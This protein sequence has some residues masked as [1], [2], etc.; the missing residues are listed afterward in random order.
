MTIYKLLM[1]RNQEMNTFCEANKFHYEAFDFTIKES[2]SDVFKYAQNDLSTVYSCNK[3]RSL[4]VGDL[5]LDVESDQLFL[6]RGT[7]YQ[8]IPHDFLIVEEEGS[9]I[10]ILKNVK[11]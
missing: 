2:L 4:S 7:H 5:I 1:P 6:V 11:L 3:R 10:N 9:D 8:E